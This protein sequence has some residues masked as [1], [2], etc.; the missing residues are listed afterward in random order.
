[1]IKVPLPDENAHIQIFNI[2]AKELLR[3]GLMKSDIDIDRIISATSGLT[4]AHVERL[5][6]LAVI[7]AMR[8]DV[9]SRGQLDISEEESENLRVCN[10]DFTTAIS[11][12]LYAEQ[13]ES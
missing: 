7:N 10:V 6:R 8:R 2:Y 12:I 1:V 11:K 13:N 9:L 5:V 3:N 4:D